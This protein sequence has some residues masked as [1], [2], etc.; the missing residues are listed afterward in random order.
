MSALLDLRRKHGITWR[1]LLVWEPAPLGCQ[2]DNLDAHLRACKLVDVFSPNHLE[3]G[4][5]VDGRTEQ[6]PAFSRLAVERSAKTFWDSGIGLRGEGVAV[7]RAGEHGC[8]TISSASGS[9]WLPPFY[10]EPSMKV[11]DPTGAGNTF[12]GA[13]SVTLQSTGDVQEAC[14]SATVAA[15]FALEQFG[16]PKLSTGTSRTEELWNGSSVSTRTGEYRAR[17]RLL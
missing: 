1:P 15:S 7:I 10:S 4:Y 16:Y 11:V 8:L 12:L 5:L 17:S 6:E 2:R 9:Q 14:I 3:L 13:F